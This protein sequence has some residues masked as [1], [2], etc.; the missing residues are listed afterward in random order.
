MN[1]QLPE[2]ILLLIYG[3]CLLF[4][5]CYSL[6]QLHLTLLF[7]RSQKFTHN[8]Q[9]TSFQNWPL[10]TV[11][12]PIY[13]ERYVVE[14][15]LDAV[16]AFDYPKASLQ[17][18]VLDD[19]TDETVGIIARKVQYFRELGLNIEH[20]RRPER[21]GY[22]AGAL[23]HGLQTATGEYI[24]I[25]DADFVPQP[26][27]LKKLLPYFSRPDIGMVQARWGHLN[28]G[29]SLLTRLQAFGLDAHFTVEQAGRNAGNYFINF[30]G[31]AGVWRKSCIESAGGWE[32]DTLTE[33]LDLSYRAQLKNW[34]FVYLPHLVVPAE[35]PPNMAAL[36]SQQYRWTKGAAETLKKHEARIWKSPVSLSTK[37]HGSFHLLNST[38]FVALLMAAISSLPLLFFNH[39]AA[40]N[41]LFRF[42]SI[43]LS[44]FFLLFIFYWLAYQQS[45]RSGFFVFLPRFLLFLMMMMGLSLHN[46]IAVIEGFIGRK[47]PFIRTPKYN[48]TNT[49]GTWKNRAYTFTAISKI[50]WLEGLLAVIFWLAVGAAFWLHDFRLIVFHAMLALGFS[51]VFLFSIKERS[52]A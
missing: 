17:I 16:S 46:S 31:T 27:F 24:C 38:V 18:Q 47:T 12:L 29:F 44:G 2:L 9:E 50:T 41:F 36:K 7:R 6:L 4:I 48:L 15:L 49:S 25:F 34:K 11:Q 35:L 32:A 51:L 22:K 30:N 45:E 42:T 14:R 20:V 1:W 3:S 19:S 10:V 28:A 8:S 43:F 13:N 52:A 37:L 5:F 23:Q 40:S 21:T 39:S 26:D 33:D